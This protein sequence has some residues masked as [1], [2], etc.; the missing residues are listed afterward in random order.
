MDWAQ[1]LVVILAV[2][3]GIFLLL[4]ITLIIMLIKVTHQIRLVAG[5]AERTVKVLEKTIA[6][7][8]GLASPLLI[9]KMVAKFIKKYRTKGDS[10]VNEK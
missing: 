9:M 5:S 8:R 7:A 2:F 1:V 6:Q 3:L 4:G 10:H